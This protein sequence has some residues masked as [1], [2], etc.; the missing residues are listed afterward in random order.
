MKTKLIA[1]LT[2]VIGLGGIGAASAADM[3]VKAKPAPLPVEVWNWSGFYIGLNAGGAWSDNSRGYTV[4]VPAGVGAVSLADCGTPAGAVPLVIPAGAN[5]FGLSASCGSDSSFIGGGQIGYN[6]QAGAWVF[7]LEADG[8]WQSLTERSFTRFGPNGFVPFGGF[9]NDTAYFKQETTALGTFRGR[10]GYAGGPWLI[11]ATGG[12]AVGNVDHTFTEVAA[13]GNVCLALAPVGVC[14]SVS[15]SD[16]KWGWTVGA[17]FEWMF[18]RNWS[19]GAEYLYVDLGRTT[20]T[21][22]PIAGTI[23]GSV[24]TA[25]FDDREHVARVKLNYHFGGPV[26]AKY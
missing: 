23:F 22:A 2:G 8:A 9:A 6:W 14:R 12:A 25:A 10:V 19:V 20:L 4:G 13:P 1:L 17:G 7:G 16:T 26:V 15:G 18:A 24:S 5:P 3:A 11:Y 21:L